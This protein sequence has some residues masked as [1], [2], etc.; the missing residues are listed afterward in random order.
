MRKDQFAQLISEMNMLLVSLSIHPLGA[1]PLSP[2]K[3]W[4]NVE[5]ESNS[6]REFFSL[7][8]DPAISVDY[9]EHF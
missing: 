4:K 2:P 5:F 7:R 6:K 1:P 8:Y 3:L 9:F